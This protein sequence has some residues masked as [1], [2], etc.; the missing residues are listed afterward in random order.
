MGENSSG[1]PC[2]PGWQRGIEAARAA[3]RCGART[4]R[5]TI[6]Q[7]PAMPNGRCKTHGGR[8]P[9]APKGERNGQ[10]AGWVLHRGGAG[11]AATPPRPDPADA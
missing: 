8:S 4:R 5:G 11:G 2:G 9:G 7:G 1:Q 3:D 6:C 10:L